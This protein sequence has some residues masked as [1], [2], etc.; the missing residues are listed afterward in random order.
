[1][2]ALHTL[3]LLVK[4][5]SR[6]IREAWGGVMHVDCVVNQTCDCNKAQLAPAYDE[7][8]AEVHPCAQT[9]DKA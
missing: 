4:H 9:L 3:M 5:S 8:E 1:M 2:P 7:Q 6:G